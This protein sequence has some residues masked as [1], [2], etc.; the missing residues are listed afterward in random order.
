MPIGVPSVSHSSRM[1]ASGSPAARK[2]AMKRS[3][4]TVE[5]LPRRRAGSSRGLDRNSARR[6]AMM[7]SR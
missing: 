1:S 5:R 4:C 7:R 6:A 2:M 3:T